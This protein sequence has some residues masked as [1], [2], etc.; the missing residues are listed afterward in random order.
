MRER[1]EVRVPWARVEPILD[2][3]LELAPSDW[4][5]FLADACG[6]DDALREHVASL[7]A[8]RSAV[9]DFLCTPPVVVP[10][11]VA[12]SPAPEDWAGREVGA[13]RVVRALGEG[14]MGR[15]FLAERADGRFTRAVAVKVLH[16]HLCRQENV[17]QRFRR[18]AEAVAA[19][20]HPNIV[21]IYDVAAAGSE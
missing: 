9:E 12:N 3:A 13:Y 11:G 16:A 17:P 5:G 14:G 20:E 10:E 6:G 7:L 4:R 1:R 19:L 8:C 21:H 15:V 2:R 18:E